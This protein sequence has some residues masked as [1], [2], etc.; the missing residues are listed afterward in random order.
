MST[1]IE[2]IVIAGAGQAGVQA[3]LSLRIEGFAGKIALV[4]DEAFLPYQRPPLSKAYLKGSVT[5]DALQI[6]K[7]ALLAERNIDLHLGEAVSGIDREKKCL[8]LAQGKALPY[9]RLILATGTRSRPLSIPGANLPGVVMLRTVTDADRLARLLGGARQIAIIGGGFIGL[10]FAAVARELD[11]QVIVIEASSRV[12]MRAV[13][14]EISNFFE[15]THRDKGATVICNEGVS[16]IVSENNQLK[17]IRLASG[18]EFPADLVMIGVGALPNC[19]IAEA[20]GLAVEDGILVNDALQTSDPHIFAIGDCCRVGA[21][22]GRYLTRIESVQNA[23]DQGR[24]AAYVIMK[25]PSPYKAVPWFWSD[26]YEYK[27]QMAGLI[28]EADTQIIK[29]SPADGKFSVFS[30]KS[31]VFIG[32]ESVNSPLDHV[33]TRKALNENIAL[34]PDYLSDA[35]VSIKQAIEAATAT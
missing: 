20:A 12:M 19:G 7:P 17:G 25:A 15:K 16:E 27:L 6:A 4:G 35:T 5:C 29:G 24:H 22:G 23:T 1:E 18:K 9:D 11:K 8:L 2:R 3:A 33:L 32:S 21:D 13:S 14:P 34:S 26:Q 28:F 10:E 31:G 30:F